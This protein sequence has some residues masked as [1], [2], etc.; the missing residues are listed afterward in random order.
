MLVRLQGVSNPGAPVQNNGP[1]LIG[2]QPN[3]SDLIEDGVVRNIAP[4]ELTFRFDDAQIIN[5][6]TAAGIV[7]VELVEM[8][9]LL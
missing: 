2:V 7:S 4:R 6:A 8:V 5:A 1:R 9:P 3:N